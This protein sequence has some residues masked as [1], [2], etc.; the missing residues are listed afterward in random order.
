MTEIL[1]CVN[2]EQVKEADYLAYI[3][4]DG[5]TE[6]AAHLQT[7]AYCRNELEIY[8]KF[9]NLLH[10][11]FGLRWKSERTL[12][13]DTQK[14]GE[15]A[16]NLLL[17]VEQSYVEAHLS[18]CSFCSAEFRSLYEWLPEPGQPELPINNSN[19]EKA[20][21]W[22]RRVVANLISVG[23]SQ[24]NMAMVAAGLRGNL[25]GIPQVFEAEEVQI[26]V[27]VQSAG[28]RRSELEVVGEVQSSSH[29]LEELEGAEVRLLKENQ[30]LAIETIN[31][32][33]N[34]FF[35]NVPSFPNFNLEITLSDKIVQV[36]GVE[37]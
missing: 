8:R 20:Q 11:N 9:D 17:P 1:N 23:R 6:F 3:N 32:T 22:L 30:L 24:D 7:C 34:F 16:L 33:G 18:G 5:R 14:L 13:L 25:E 15:Y 35:D 2:S 36:L 19:W 31:D 21:N 4:K 29:T 10:R 37:V 27:T 28:L 26:M 12:C